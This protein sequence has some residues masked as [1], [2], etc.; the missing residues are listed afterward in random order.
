[1]GSRRTATTDILGQRGKEA[2]D[3]DDSDGN[4]A[5]DENRIV[6]TAPRRTTIEP[7][8]RGAN[9]KLYNRRESGRTIGNLKV[10]HSDEHAEPAPDRPDHIITR[11][12]G[13]T[14][15]DTARPGGSSHKNNS[16]TKSTHLGQKLRRS[17][18]TCQHPGT[19]KRAPSHV[20]IART[21]LNSRTEQSVV[22]PIDR[23]HS[24]NHDR[25]A[26]ATVDTSRIEVGDKS[27]AQPG[28]IRQAIEQKMRTAEGYEN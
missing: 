21:P 1:M 9:E 18:L 13:G 4:E 26:I 7:H 17:K 22:P 25:H 20:D 28:A 15:A 12:N 3:Q 27:K 19:T 23:H 24:I 8:Q 16:Q 5:R 2:E 14:E 11:S 10:E 6:A